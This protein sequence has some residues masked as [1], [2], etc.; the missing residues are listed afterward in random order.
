M[1]KGHFLPF[2]M[3]DIGPEPHI[4]FYEDVQRIMGSGCTDPNCKKDHSEDILYCHALCHPKA[5][6]WLVLKKGKAQAALLCSKCNKRIMFIQ[7][8]RKDGG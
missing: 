8:A 6:T 7:L 2:D 3:S 1:S 5:P 4:V